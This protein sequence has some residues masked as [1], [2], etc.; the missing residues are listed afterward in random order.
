MCLDTN[1][2]FGQGKIQIYMGENFSQV[3]WCYK[4]GI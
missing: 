2:V 3:V 1:M 4:D